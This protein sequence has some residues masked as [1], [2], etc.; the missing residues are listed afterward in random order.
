MSEKKGKKILFLNGIFDGHFTGTVEL[1]K[2]LV[3]LGHD[4]TCYVL[5][6]FLDRMKDTGATLKPFEAVVEQSIIDNLPK[7]APP[8][9]LNL[10]F[11]V[12]FIDQVLDYA[13]KNNEKGKY[14]YLVIDRFFDGNEMNKIFQAKEVISIYTST[15]TEEPPETKKFYEDRQRAYNKINKKYNLNLREYVTMHY[16]G[17]SKYKLMLT[18]KLFHPPTKTLNDS[19]YFIGP[20]IEKRPED[21]S[22]TFKKDENKKLIYISLGTLFNQNIEFFKKC[23]EAFKDNEKYQVI[24]TVGRKSDVKQLGEIPKNF[25]IYNYAPQLQ[26]LP[27]TDVFIF[28]GGINSINEGLLLNKT[29]MIIIP[30]EADQFVN[31]GLV[32]KHGLGIALNNNS[33]TPELLRD[34]VN[35]ILN[36]EEKYKVGIDKIIQSFK[37]ARSQRKAILEKLFV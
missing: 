12:N 17:D 19:F 35:N 6:K 15:F 25:L 14:E 16:L 8:F 13:I 31:A 10:F 29:P 1:V 30:Q 26:I 3:S 23:I 5:N 36:N 22:F 7:R 32:V 28:H 34:S 11:F 21:K 20:S 9:V 37:E 2:E 33:I 4:V 18:S 24:M 27:M